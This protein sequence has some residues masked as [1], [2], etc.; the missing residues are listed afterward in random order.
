M[1]EKNL[2]ESTSGATP[3]LPLG[4]LGKALLIV[5]L[6]GNFFSMAIAAYFGRPEF[7]DGGHMLYSVLKG[8]KPF[9]LPGYIRYTR[10]IWQTPTLCV[11]KLGLLFPGRDFTNAAIQAFN[12]AFEFHPV[13]SLAI[14][15]FILFRRE[16]LRYFV[17]PLM[18]YALCTQA[19]M[20]NAE[21]SVLDALTFFWPLFLL[22]EFKGR[23][24]ILAVFEIVICATAVAFSHETAVLFFVFLLVRTLFEVRQ[25][26]TCSVTDAAAISSSLV[27]SCWLTWRIIAPG[28]SPE[29]QF[30]ESLLGPW[31]AFRVYGMLVLISCIVAVALA[32]KYDAKKLQV[33]FERISAALAV[34]F[35]LVVSVYPMSQ[36]TPYFAYYARTTAVPLS[37]I[38]ACFLWLN[39]WLE[40]NKPPLSAQ[41][42]RAC[43]KLVVAALLA[44]ATQDLICTNGWLTGVRFVEDLA[45]RTGKSC[46]VIPNMETQNYL[47]LYG[48]TPYHLPYNVILLQKR[49]DIQYLVLNFEE[50]DPCVSMRMTK[51]YP[52]K[53]FSWSRKEG[54]KMWPRSQVALQNEY[55]NFSKVLIQ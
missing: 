17:F 20:A 4:R 25:K 40:K 38:V 45:A 14:S 36:L 27:G 16:R 50:S 6:G 54:I 47:N 12:F 31:S 29:K 23:E 13:L 19:V 39:N 11:L 7:L 26:G 48:F 52:A 42:N 53:N 35:F 51:E 21:S 37:C 49:R 1:G 8:A 2:K 46:V 44:S 22:I 33:F 41:L 9:I 3:S 34:L 43:W 32:K 55:F 28:A 10:M 5:G 24:S 15:W 18:S 30:F